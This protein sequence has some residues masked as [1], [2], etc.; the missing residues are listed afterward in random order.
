MKKPLTEFSTGVIDMAK[1]VGD[2]VA[3][4]DDN[5]IGQRIDSNGS[6]K[7]KVNRDAVFNAI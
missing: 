5:C 7:P 2:V 3:A 1:N 6:I 4:A